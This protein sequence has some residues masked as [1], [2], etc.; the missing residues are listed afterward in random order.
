MTI[1]MLSEGEIGDKDLS[2]HQYKVIVIIFNSIDI[3]ITI[4]II[5]FF[6]TGIGS[7]KPICLYIRVLE[8]LLLTLFCHSRGKNQ[9]L[10]ANLN[11]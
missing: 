4:V 3:I 6:V 1:R 5:L 2:A 10:S 7:Y 9:I 8:V 11:I